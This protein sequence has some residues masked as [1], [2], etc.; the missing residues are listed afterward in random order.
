[1]LYTILFKH[2]HSYCLLADYDKCHWLLS[3]CLSTALVSSNNFSLPAGEVK[4]RS[5]ISVFFVL[6]RPS[7]Y[8]TN[9]AKEKKRKLPKPR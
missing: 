7:I 4:L 5:C 9:K 8:P 6:K 3:C 1:M 2:Q